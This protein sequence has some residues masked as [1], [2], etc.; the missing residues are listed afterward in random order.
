M[1]LLRYSKRRTKSLLK[2]VLPTAPQQHAKPHLSL[3][4]A[5]YN[6]DP[7]IDEFLASVFTQSSKIQRFEVIIVDDGS[8]DNTAKIIEGWQARYPKH[9]RYIHQENSGAGAARNAGIALAH[10]AWISFPD[11]DDFLDVDYFRTMLKEAETQQKTPLLAVV[12]NMIY[13]YEDDERFS[14]THPLRYR[15]SSPVVKKQSHNLGNYMQFATNSV[16]INRE[17]FL[18]HGMTFDP[19][20]VPS[21]EDGHLF[22]RLLIAQPNQTVSFVSGAKYYYRKRSEK[23]SLID[24]AKLQLSWY[25][26]QIRFGY[27]DLLDFAKRL[28]GFVP[29]HIQRTCLYDIFWRFRHLVDYEERAAFLSE[30]QKAQFLKLLETAFDYID[31]ETIETFNL[32]GCTEEHKVAL[33]ACYKSQRRSST[34]VYLQRMDRQASMMQFSVL[35]GGTDEITLNILVNGVDTAPILPSEKRAQFIGLPYYRQRFFWLKLKDGDDVTFMVDGTPCRVKRGA[36][37]LGNHPS[38]FDLRAALQPTAPKLMAPE[39]RRLREHVVAVRETYRGGRV[40]MDSITKADDNAEHLYRHMLVTGRANRSWFVLSKN[41]PDWPRLEAEGF[42]LLPFGSDD[43]IAALMNADF[44]ISSHID[45]FV[46]HPV[47]RGDFADLAQSQFIFLQHGV[48]MNDLSRWLNGK[49]P[50]LFVT[51]MPKECE[52]ISSQKSPYIFTQR[53]VILTGLPRHDAL[54]TK[55][56]SA[57]ANTILIMPTW[58]KYLTNEI[59][60]P[61]TGEL[62][63]EK[64]DDFHETDFARNWT[65]LLNAPRLHDLAKENNLRIT[66]APHQNLTMYLDDMSIPEDI[67]VIDVRQDAPYQDLFANARIAITDY[68]SAVTDVAYLGRPLIYFQF[69]TSDM[70]SGNHVVKPGY[71]SFENDGFGPVVNTS[72]SV[73]DNLEAA[74]CGEENQIFGQ[75]RDN[76]F[77]LRDGRCCER[78]CV[79]LDKL[80]EPSSS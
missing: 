8:T 16:W 11:A 6:V 71:F 38:W 29:K 64:I 80:S 35:D 45:H 56:K 73:L 20:I 46:L 78:I 40:L 31:A 30:D 70:F 19:R 3:I 5:A 65:E 10:G 1:N 36:V 47:P 77:P 28:R 69:D 58:R 49:S 39:T 42:Q 68:S 4:V 61:K 34:T 44:L 62:I 18:K 51:T 55:A 9:I 25:D 63:R 15:F 54:L 13:Y 2:T 21:F 22:N 48:I 12:S 32:A 52:A 26:D 79:A 72:D 41:S 37:V 67:E 53:E 14:D 76:A 75:R 50:R 24:T 43:H 66:F 27:I 57:Q 33:L 59:S 60:V 74:L 17:T 7:Y 23:S